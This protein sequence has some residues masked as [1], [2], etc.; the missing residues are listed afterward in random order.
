VRFY[1]QGK[2]VIENGTWK[3][4]ELRITLFEPSSSAAFEQGKC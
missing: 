2:G 4:G 1:D 3:D